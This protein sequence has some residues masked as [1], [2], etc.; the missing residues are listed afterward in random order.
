MEHIL[1]RNIDL[2]DYNDAG[3]E[4]QQDFK[5]HINRIGNFTL[6]YNTDNSSIGN[7][8]FKDKI[9]MYKSS[10]FKITN[11]IAEPLTTEVKSGMDTKLFNLIND[12]EKTYTPNE[13]GHFSKLLIEQRSEEVANAL[14]KI[15]TKEYD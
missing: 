2:S 5:E 7:K 11:V 3:F 9:E 8:M 12:L 6:L 4:N 13:N 14:Y 1:S 10:D 15:L